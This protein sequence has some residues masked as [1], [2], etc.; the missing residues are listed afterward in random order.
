MPA[1]SLLHL[2]PYS[3]KLN[4]IENVWAYLQSNKLSKRIFDIDDAIIVPAATLR[5]GLLKSLSASPQLEP[6]IGHRSPE[7]H[8]LITRPSQP[9]ALAPMTS[10]TRDTPQPK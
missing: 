3:S 4:P 7:L 8:R 9:R 2:L 5:H 10:V 1:I 6:D